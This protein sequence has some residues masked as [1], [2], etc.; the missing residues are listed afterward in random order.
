MMGKRDG[1]PKAAAGLMTGLCSE[2][3]NHGEGNNGGPSKAEPISARPCGT[4]PKILE[5][6]GLRI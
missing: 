4:G 3:S 6:K 1:L 5:R 2:P